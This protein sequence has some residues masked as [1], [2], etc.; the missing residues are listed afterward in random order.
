[1]VFSVGKGFDGHRINQ[2][3]R[4]NHSGFAMVNISFVD[5]LPALFPRLKKPMTECRAPLIV[6][7]RK[8]MPLTD[9]SIVP[10]LCVGMQP[11]TLRVPWN[12]ER[13]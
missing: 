11:G 6:P 12:A 13:P 9:R 8:V 3:S 10:T 4:G 7:T 5:Y 2:K 1:M